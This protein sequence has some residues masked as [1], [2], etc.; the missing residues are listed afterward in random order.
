M[1]T[2]PPNVLWIC[3]DQQR[4]DTISALNNSQLNTPNIDKL[5]ATG[6][7]FER[8]Y[9]QSPIC[10]PSRASFLTGMYPSSVHACG[11]GNEHWA[12]AAPLVTA[13]LADAGYDCALAGKFHLAGARGRIEPRPKHD[14]YRLFHWSHDPEDQWEAGHAYGDWLASMGHDLGEMRKK[15]HDIPPELHQTTWCSD[16]AID[17]MEADHGG[18]PWLMSVNIFDPHEPFDPPQQYLDRF[19]VESLSGPK[20]RDSDLEAQAKL[21]ET[22]FQH[23]ARRPQEFNAKWIQAAYYAMIELIDDNVGRMLDS[24]ERTGQRDNTIIIFMSDHGEAL[25]DHGLLLK[26]CRFYEGLARVPLIL[27]WPCR[28]LEGARR[29]SLVELLDIAPTLLDLAGVPIPERMQGI[30]LRNLLI[31]AE[32][33]DHHRD[34]VRCEYFQAINPSMTRNYS[35]TF[36]TMIRDERYKLVVYHGHGLGELFDLETDPDEFDN[37]WDDPALIETKLALMQ[38]SFDALALAT[39]IGPKQITWF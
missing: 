28:F 20:F 4:F 9:C 25:G 33:Q 19:D 24:L 30:S 14:G 8:A 7:A 27:S 26:G 36:A 15:P 5:V 11:N 22:D 34:F 35:G 17:F 37:L 1:N 18:K 10:T 3:T 16:R 12:E 2:N 32:A 29:Q 6:V 39:D 23:P 38:R 13:L 31:D 21:S